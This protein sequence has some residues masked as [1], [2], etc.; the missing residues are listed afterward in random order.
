M[1]Y[2]IYDFAPSTALAQQRYT[3]KRKYVS[4]FKDYLIISRDSVKVM[5]I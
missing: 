3:D 2:D 5:V 1:N 4:M